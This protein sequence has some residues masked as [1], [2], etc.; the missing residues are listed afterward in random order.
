MIGVSPVVMAGTGMVTGSNLGATGAGAG[1]ATTSGC[2]GGKGEGSFI[3]LAGVASATATG[4]VTGF[5]ALSTVTVGSGSTDS[6]LVILGGVEGAVTGSADFV[7]ALAIS[8]VP[9]ISSNSTATKA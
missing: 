4:R 5:T 3:T 8:G 1:G 6:V 7:S 9:L 2:G